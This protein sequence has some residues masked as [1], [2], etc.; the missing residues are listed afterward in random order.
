MKRLA[1]VALLAACASSRP[2]PV[3]AV[4][5]RPAPAPAPARID[6]ANREY[7]LHDGL[8]ELGGTLVAGRG[9]MTFYNHDGGKG[10]PTLMRLADVAE[11]GDSGERVTVVHIVPEDPSG[12]GS[13]WAYFAIDDGAPRLLNATFSR[14]RDRDPSV[15]PPPPP[16]TCRRECPDSPS[17]SEI[18]VCADGGIFVGDHEY[19]DE[20][21]VLAAVRPLRRADVRVFFDAEPSDDAKRSIADVQRWLRRSHLATVPREVGPS[22][23]CCEWDL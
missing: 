11:R 14:E 2:A 6:W 5:T 17:P 9:S 7:V 15:P 20:R 19:L 1:L 13:W 8:W 3:V 10:P 12:F 4:A 16:P 22:C 21:E 18:H 23:V